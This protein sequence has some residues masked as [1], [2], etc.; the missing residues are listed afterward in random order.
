MKCLFVYNPVSGRGRIA[1]KLPYILRTLG[2][3]YGTVDA[4]A[5]VRPGDMTAA[6]RAG[7]EKYDAV[8]FSGGDGSFNEAVQGLCEASH[9][10]EVGYIPSGT[11]ND[12]A[13]SLG[14]PRRLRRALKVITGG[15]NA[16]L[17]CMKINDRYAMYIVAAGAF[18]SAPYT[19]PQSLKKQMGFI[20][21]GIEGL[22]KNLRF[23]VFGVTLSDGRR[24]VRTDSVFVVLMNGRYVAGIPLNRGSSM[25][26]GKIEAALIHQRKNPG[27]FGKIR[28]FLALARLFLLGYRVRE[29]QITRLEGSHFEIAADESVVWN[30]DGEKGIAGNVTVDVVPGRIR[31]LVPRRRDV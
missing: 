27:F 31:L 21:Y 30:F 29:K 1:K 23:D 2:E 4:Y 25:A 17:D 6:V 28:A 20:A 7:A 24:T 15:A 14:I 16:M 11:V 18:T 12:V 5:T 22:K 8:V 10:P 9:M 19:T 13:H 3:K 26:D